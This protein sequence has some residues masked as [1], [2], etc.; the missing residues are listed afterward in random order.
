[1]S[2]ILMNMIVLKSTHRWQ[3]PSIE[4]CTDIPEHLAP[5]PSP[6]LRYLVMSKNKVIGGEVVDMT[7][8]RI[9]CSCLSSPL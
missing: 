8:V 6:R 7:G 1:M 5:G 9:C 3:H 4:K 2:F